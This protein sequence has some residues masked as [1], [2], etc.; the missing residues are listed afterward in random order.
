[1]LDL[2][3]LRVL[4][5]TINIWCE[6][7]PFLY[8]FDIKYTYFLR[9]AKNK[10]FFRPRNYRSILNTFKNVYVLTKNLRATEFYRICKS[11]EKHT[12]IEG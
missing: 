8:V 1:M 3:L 9:A 6:N 7:V 12:Q 11:C 10:L 2:L 4:L 5:Y